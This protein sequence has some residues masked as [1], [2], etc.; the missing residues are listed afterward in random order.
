MRRT[1]V[2]YSRRA[3]V[4]RSLHLAASLVW[5]SGCSDATHDFGPP[6]TREWD[7]TVPSTYRGFYVAH[8]SHQARVGWYANVRLAPIYGADERDEERRAA[9]VLDRAFHDVI[10]EDWRLASAQAPACDETDPETVRVAVFEL[11]TDQRRRYAVPWNVRLG[12]TLCDA[13]AAALGWEEVLAFAYEMIARDRA[14][15][16]AAAQQAADD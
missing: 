2:T 4:W 7:I 12:A 8:L 11:A 14:R 1:E 3:I 15:M 6:G 10:D 5:V 13:N 9:A 16:E